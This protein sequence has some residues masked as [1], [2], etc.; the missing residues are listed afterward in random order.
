MAL[1]IPCCELARC[2]KCVETLVA[3]ISVLLQDGTA[4]SF[5]EWPA[6]ACALI[7]AT[8]SLEVMKC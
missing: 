3:L 1:V 8:F 2:C 6:K 7:D 5:E 4:C